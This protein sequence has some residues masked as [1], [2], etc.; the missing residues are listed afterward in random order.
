MSNLQSISK[1]EE[2]KKA[3]SE[4]GSNETATSFEDSSYD[5]GPGV[6]A[7]KSLQAAADNSPSSNSI[8]QLQAMADESIDNDLNGIV[9]L[10][11]IADEMDV[12]QAQPIQRE[13]NKISPQQTE[14]SET[15]IESQETEEIEDSD[16]DWVEIDENTY[17]LSTAKNGKWWFYYVN[18]QEYQSVMDDDTSKS[19]ERFTIEEFNSLFNKSEEALTSPE[20][21]ALTSPEVEAL[22]SPEEEA[23]TSPEY[24]KEGDLAKLGIEGLGSTKQWNILHDNNKANKKL[25]KESKELDN[26]GIVATFNVHVDLD[27]QGLSLINQ[28]ETADVGHT[29]ISIKWNDPTN[30]PEDI[31]TR[32]KEF[33]RGG[34]NS[35]GFWPKMWKDNR[36]W[37]D[38]EVAEHRGDEAEY[39]STDPM[40]NY[41]A[42]HMLHP[43]REHTPMATYS[44]DIKRAQADSIMEFANSK[45]DAKYSLLY[46]NCTNFAK[47]ATQVAGLKPPSFGIS[48]T[49]TGICYP[50]AI[51]K[52][53]IARNKKDRNA[54]T[55]NIESEL[56]SDIE[57]NDP[58]L[59]V[60]KN[61]E[62]TQNK[63]YP[64]IMNMGEPI[65]GI[66]KDEVKSLYFDK[67][68]LKF[69]LLNEGDK[70]EELL[71]EKEKQEY[72]K[73]RDEEGNTHIKE[74]MLQNVRGFVKY[75][76]P[77]KRI[78]F[79][80]EYY[81]K[82]K[83]SELLSQN[84]ELPDT[85]LESEE[86]EETEETE[87]SVVFE[88]T[89]TEGV[90]ILSEEIHG[91]LWHYYEKGDFYK[92]T[93]GD[94]ESE[95]LTREKF[96]SL[97]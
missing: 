48:G 51:Y 54:K 46:Y 86:I 61:D 12:S 10:Q 97:T 43:D 84:I 42:G 63:Q 28:I 96:E 33:L 31:P 50:D 62:W 60:I 32:H 79:D 24:I 66:W 81:K 82:E 17:R 41:V 49:K 85:A 18:E 95:E 16:S 38:P 3:I 88:R 8:T 93:M 64:N 14:M 55:I 13:T 29:W 21:E 56:D 23:L 91:K 6:M 35:M 72:T 59:L 40:N 76:S 2:A 68:K 57:F 30:V 87:G 89:S 37:S 73:Y 15:S 4:S 77:D 19:S 44:Y 83:L 71:V 67:T 22:N 25:L 9:Q 26:K 34:I 53:I 74:R 75:V 45:I 65:K 52:S 11:S 58:K 80:T 78:E 1:P 39:Y 94:I 69:F 92:Y 20:E 7:L 5:F 36:D 27:A 47:E 90:Y 70:L